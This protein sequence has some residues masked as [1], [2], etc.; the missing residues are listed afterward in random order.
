MKVATSISQFLIDKMKPKWHCC[1]VI[2]PLST[3]KIPCK[4]YHWGPMDPR[5]QKVFGHKNLTQINKLTLKI[6]INEQLN[7]KK[8]RNAKKRTALIMP[9][10]IL[11]IQLD[12]ESKD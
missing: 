3:K 8:V 9:N 2:N 1:D 10:Y 7:T 6:V 11:Y 5:F 12:R 4:L